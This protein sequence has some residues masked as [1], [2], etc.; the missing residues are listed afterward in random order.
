VNDEINRAIDFD[1][2]GHVLNQHLKI[3]TLSNL[4]KQ[5]LR[6]NWPPHQCDKLAWGA[7]DFLI[8]PEQASGHVS[9]KKPGSTR[10]KQPGTRKAI[11]PAADS[12]CYLAEILGKYIT[13]FRAGHAGV[14]LFPHE[15][16]GERFKNEFHPGE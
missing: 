15:K 4:P 5:T 7:Q 16:A 11:H 14:L 3:C 6:S 13:V 10:K 1:R 12:C 2:L 9:T 8:E